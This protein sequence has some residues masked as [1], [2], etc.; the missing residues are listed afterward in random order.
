MHHGTYP[1]PAELPVLRALWAIGTATHGEVLRHLEGAGL[2]YHSNAPTL[3]LRS[4][5][6]KGLV[7]REPAPQGTRG[8]VYAARVGKVERA[9]MIVEGL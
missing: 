9:Q 5:A 3:L 1:T 7:A 6:D 2:I 4:L 8:S